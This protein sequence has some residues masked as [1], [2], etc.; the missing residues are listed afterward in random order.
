MSKKI[1]LVICNKTFSVFTSKEIKTKKV[2]TLKN[3][4]VCE[5]SG[6]AYKYFEINTLKLCILFIIKKLEF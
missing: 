5:D 1:R 2:L 3:N 6:T 4:S